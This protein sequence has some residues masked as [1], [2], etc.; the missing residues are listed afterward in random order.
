MSSTLPRW[1]Q[2]LLDRHPSAP[3]PTADD[4]MP[5]WLAGELAD[6][7][8]W[9]FI[10]GADARRRAHP[11]FLIEDVRSQPRLLDETLRLREQLADAAH[12]FTAAGATRIIFT[13]CG[14]AYFCAQFGAFLFR[15]WTGLDCEAIESLELVNYGARTTGDRRTVL[16]AQ[17]ATGGSWETIAAVRWAREQGLATLGLTNAATSPLDDLCDRVVAL[18]TGQRCGPDVTV[19]TTRL[20]MLY[21][22]ALAWGRKIDVL[23]GARASKLAAGID[24]LP[25]MA[26]TFLERE[27][28]RLEELAELIG[29]TSAL[30]FVGGGPNWYSA[31]ECALKVEEEASIPCKAYRPA[32]YPHDAIALLS[33]QTTTVALAPPGASYTRVVDSL[34]TGQAAQSRGVALATEDDAQLA[35]LADFVVRVPAQL[36]EMF[37]PPLATIFGQTLGYY[38]GIRRGVNPD[39]LKTDDLDHAR[40]W[41]TS[42][43]LGS[44]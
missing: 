6:I 10:R 29:E 5:S 8:L 11:Y 4:P 42:F 36:D 38:L 19:I 1:A 18:P 40:A 7:P 33:P 27:E 12:Q 25:Q 37:L 41:L 31:R 2:R 21:L 44:H 16:V 34:R 15:H 43:P 39:A 9:A 23:D 35:A 14:S 13:G 17:S 24:A 30:L 28:P 22:L 20:A 26:A 3:R 32:E